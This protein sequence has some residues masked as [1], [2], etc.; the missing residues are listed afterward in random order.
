MTAIAGASLL[1]L[2]HWRRTGRSWLLYLGCFLLGLGITAK[3]LFIW[4]VLA[5]GLCWLVLF[6]APRLGTTAL[7]GLV[8]ARFFSAR[9][10]DAT[11]GEA[12]HLASMP[13]LGRLV[14]P[15]L[16]AGLILLGA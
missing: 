13:G 6:V 14:R 11:A 4:Y 8:P 2:L 9:S 7:R 3:I 10:A 5:I 1:C 12:S 16:G 15:T